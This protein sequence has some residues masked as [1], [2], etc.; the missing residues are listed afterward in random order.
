MRSAVRT[1]CVAGC[2]MLFLSGS[3]FAEKGKSPKVL[4]QK[5]FLD[6]A[7]KLKEKTS[8]TKIDKVQFANADLREVAL[9]LIKQTGINIVVDE[10]IFQSTSK[11]N[12]KVTCYLQDMSLL[13]ILDAILRPKGLDYVFTKNYIWISTKDKI[14]DINV[15][16]RK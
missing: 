14:M 8:K 16:R 2:L 9:F 3:S 11:I 15:S 4:Y 7:K 5:E 1:I 10:F 6:K 12:T 13:N